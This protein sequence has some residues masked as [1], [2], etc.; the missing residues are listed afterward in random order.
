MMPFPFSGARGAGAGP[1][2]DVDVAG[3]LLD[4]EGAAHGAG[5]EAPHLGAAVDGERL[6]EERVHVH[7][8]ALLLGV[9][10]RRPQ[11]L[12][13]R[14]GGGLRRVAQHRQRL[15]HLHAAD[16]V[17]D[18]PHLAR[19]HSQEREARVRPC[20][21]FAGAGARGARRLLLGLGL[22]HVHL[23]LLP[24]TG[25]GR[26]RDL[27]LGRVAVEGAR[28]ENSPSLCPTMFSVTKTG[29]NLRPLWT[30]KVCP[31]KSGRMVLRRDQVLMTD[32][33]FP[34][35]A[36]STFLVRC[37]SAKGPFL[38]ERAMSW[39]LVPASGACCARP[40]GGG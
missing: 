22:G 15:A 1:E 23:S 20:R 3:A 19:R 9:R 17:G 12:G 31:T 39:F 35:F 7:V 21:R 25:G 18:E 6:H 4:A 29:T 26:R 32:F 11:E 37:L 40:A 36:S 33:L 10:H 28:R 38:M 14:L 5:H 13:E 16:V 24:R 8:A 30:A 2:L 34:L 27:L